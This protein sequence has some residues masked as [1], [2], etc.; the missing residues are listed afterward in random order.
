MDERDEEDGDEEEGEYLSMEPLRSN[1]MIDDE[2]LE[3]YV[4]MGEVPSAAVTTMSPRES[5]LLSPTTLVPLTPTATTANKD[6]SVSNEGL[7]LDLEVDD[8]G[9]TYLDTRIIAELLNNSNNSGVGGAESPG[10]DLGGDLYEEPRLVSPPVGAGRPPG[11]QGGLPDNESGQGGTD[12]VYEESIFEFRSPI[13]AAK[14]VEQRVQ[15]GDPHTPDC[16]DNIY[17]DAHLM[18]A[19]LNDGEGAGQGVE[20]SPADE[21][22]NSYGGWNLLAGSKTSSVLSALTSPQGATSPPMK[23]LVNHRY[24]KMLAAT[25]DRDS[26]SPEDVEQWSM[27]SDGL[28]PKQVNRA[29]SPLK[30]CNEPIASSPGGDSNYNYVSWELLN[31]PSA[32]DA[33]KMAMAIGTHTA[34]A[35]PT[36]EPPNSY[37]KVTRM[38]GLQSCSSP[39]PHP[40]PSLEPHP[41]P[42][43]EPHLSIGTPMLL[44]LPQTEASFFPGGG[45]PNSAGL[46]STPDDSSAFTSDNAH[47][48]VNVDNIPVETEVPPIPS[49]GKRI[50]KDI[51]SDI[52]PAPP[53][54]TATTNGAAKKKPVPNP[55][56]TMIGQ[57]PENVQ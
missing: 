19:V 7:P 57:P 48:Y 6:P 9:Y 21:S 52:I 18:L 4:V 12:D 34:D 26:S 31:Q 53:P 23:A 25:E 54:R 16:S 51:S 17:M 42:S 44:N 22:D 11:G 29:K 37:L 27:P 39:E 32:D 3:L 14:S 35:T 28:K 30:I 45:P 46:P 36:S 33:A 1:S 43:L 13:H 5:A 2:D 56:Y 40:P 50:S 8:R 47:L 55:R 20:L 38:S 49:R 15:S 10:S 24:I 41:P